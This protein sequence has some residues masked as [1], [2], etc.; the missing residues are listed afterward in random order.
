M[1]LTWP[2]W[3][4]LLLVLAFAIGGFL[5]GAVAQVMVV[6]GVLTGLW[7]AVFVSGWVGGHW[8]GAHPALVFLALRWLVAVLAALAVAALFQWWGD[9]LGKAVREGPL[10]WFDHACGAVVGVGLG[11]AVGAMLLLGALTFD[12]P[13]APLLATARARTTEP[14]LSGAVRICSLGEGY[15]P[16]GGWLKRRFLAA[17]RRAVHLREIGSRSRTN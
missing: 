14:I 13:S 9:H 3:V 16:G 7:A 4:L 5:Q 1:G 15:L 11:A 10:G 17:K 12:Y 2:D 8:H 6:L